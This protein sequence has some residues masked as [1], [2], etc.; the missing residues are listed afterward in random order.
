MQGNRLLDHRLLDHLG[1]ALLALVV[2]APILFSL[3]YAFLYSVGGIGLLSEGLTAVHWTAVVWSRDVWASF[4]LSLY[5]ATA[6]VLLTTGVALALALGLR[7]SLTHGPLA[8]LIYFPLALPG[9]VAAFLAFQLF[10]GGGFLARV[11]V[12]V[13][14]LATPAEIVPMV[15]D[16]WARGIV[17]THVAIAVPFFTLLFVELYASE[18]VGE[19]VGLASALG[20]SPW[21]G[22]RRVAVPV[23]LRASAAN[24]TLFFIV[25]LGSFEIPLLL[26]RQSPQMLSVLTYRKFALYDLAEK[27][28]AYVVALLYTALVFAL[29]AT[30]FG[31]RHRG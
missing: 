28:Q 23:L 5:V 18:R 1:L 21:Q 20:A 31:R 15:H 25:V 11:A 3:G 29:L 24:L 16:A 14:W 12:A 17:F 10:G 26:G 4:L 22:V 27:P 7:R 19:L 2:A 8:L 9:T 6:T 30:A 13:G